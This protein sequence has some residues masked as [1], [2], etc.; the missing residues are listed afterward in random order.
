MILLVYTV[1]SSLLLF[2][3]MLFSV[4]PCENPKCTILP[5]ASYPKRCLVTSE[6]SIVPS[7]YWPNTSVSLLGY[8]H[9]SRSFG[10]CGKQKKKGVQKVKTL[11]LTF[12]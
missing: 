11:P 10:G 9:L 1:F 2:L 8:F 4:E 12:M 7:S 6:R 5:S 3:L